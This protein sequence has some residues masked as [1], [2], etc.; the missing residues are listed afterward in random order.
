M[1]IPIDHAI[2]KYC[3]EHTPFICYTRYADDMT[4]SAV[5]SFEDRKTTW[6]IKE[7]GEKKS[8]IKDNT[9]ISEEERESKIKAIDLKIDENVAHTDIYKMVNDILKRAGAPFALNAKKLNYGNSNGRNFILGLMLNKDHEITVGHDK[10]NKL[11][12]DI[13]NFMTDY[14]NGR[15]WEIRET[16]ELAGRIAYQNQIE[17]KYTKKMLHT[18]SNKFSKDVNATIKAVLNGKTI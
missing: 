8:A 18:Y 15:C 13:Y 5:S 1:M 7:L 11:K 4:F 6:A 3:R 2:A 16:Q 12:V 17:P 9:H 10:K 14:L